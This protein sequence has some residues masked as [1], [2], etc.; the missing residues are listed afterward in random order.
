MNFFMQIVQ[1]LRK[2]SRLVDKEKVMSVSGAVTSYHSDV[3]VEENVR[4]DRQNKV[5]NLVTLFMNK[6]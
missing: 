2:N 3:M 5:F 6:A 4:Y 1:E